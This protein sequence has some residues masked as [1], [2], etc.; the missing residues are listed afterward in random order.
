MQKILKAT[1]KKQL[2]TYKGTPIK[3]TVCFSAETLQARSEWQDI[4]EVMKRR[5]LEAGIF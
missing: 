2:V 5:N 4:F 3:R 1:R